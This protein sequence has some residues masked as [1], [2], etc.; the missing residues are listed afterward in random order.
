M[1]IKIQYPCFTYSLCSVIG[2]GAGPI[3][4]I[5]NLLNQLEANIVT[6]K[7]EWLEANE[8]VYN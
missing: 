8:K 5:Y 2:K 3:F 6:T 4:G 7:P 1:A